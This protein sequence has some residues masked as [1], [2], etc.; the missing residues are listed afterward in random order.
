[1][2]FCMEFREVIE[3]PAIAASDCPCYEEDEAKT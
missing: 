2:T 3:L 1:V